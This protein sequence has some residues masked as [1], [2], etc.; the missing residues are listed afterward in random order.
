M[1]LINLLT[2][3]DDY[4]SKKSETTEIPTINITIN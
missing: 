3:A 2:D 4:Q 1:K